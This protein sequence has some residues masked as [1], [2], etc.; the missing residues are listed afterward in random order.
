M[1]QNF[2]NFESGMLSLE[3]FFNIETCLSVR[4]MK[5]MNTVF[6]LPMYFIYI[7]DTPRRSADQIS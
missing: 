7:L 5:Q 6:A 1:K 4:F 2:E 3:F